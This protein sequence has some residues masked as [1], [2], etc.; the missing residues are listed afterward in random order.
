MARRNKS[1]AGVSLFSFLDIL[2]FC[3]GG[4][5]LILISITLIS[6]ESKVKDVI[7]KVKAE[8]EEMSKKAIYLEVQRDQIIILPE[9][10]STTFE[11]LDKKGSHY[12]HLLETLNRHKEYVIFAVRPKGIM[13]FKKARG[14]AEKMG[15]DIGFEPVEE[16]WNIRAK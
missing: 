4:L 6:S 12:L 7:I 9:K 16:G 10:L 14:V 11:K 2:T 8:N 13:T 3:I 1:S 15:I 5:I